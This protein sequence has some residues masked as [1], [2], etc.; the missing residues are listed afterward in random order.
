MPME[1]F[2]VA[3]IGRAMKYA[4]AEHCPYLYKEGGI[5][6]ISAFDLTNHDSITEIP[7]CKSNDDLSRLLC[8]DNL[9]FWEKLTALSK[10]K[11][12]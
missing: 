12:I 8:S 3:R 5:C 9:P 1:N 11:A 7:R 4:T 10:T 2:K 6:E